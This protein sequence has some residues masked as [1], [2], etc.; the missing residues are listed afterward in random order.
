MATETVEET[1]RRNKN[2]NQEFQNFLDQ[3]FD[4]KLVQT[5]DT[6]GYYLSLDSFILNDMIEALRP[7]LNVIL[8]VFDSHIDFESDDWQKQSEYCITLIQAYY[9]YHEY[10]VQQNLQVL[11]MKELIKSI[12]EWLEQNE[13]SYPC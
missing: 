13:L 5:F 3:T 2:V 9:R 8:S 7:I 4:Q 6:L 11:Q 12:Q 1:A 10:L